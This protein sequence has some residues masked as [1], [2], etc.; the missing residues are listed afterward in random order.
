MT[1]SVPAPPPGSIR[2]VAVIGDVAGHLDELQTELV[3]L[4]ADGATLELPAG[5]QVIQVGDLIH[6]GPD[7][8]GVTDQGAVHD[9]G[10]PGLVDHAGG[11]RIL[12]G[13]TGLRAG[14]RWPSGCQRCRGSPAAA[15]LRQWS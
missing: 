1:G 7:S 13:D 11:T 3:R 9:V 8:A 10:Q 4:G 5:L 12:P 2:R 15:A 6:R 14:V